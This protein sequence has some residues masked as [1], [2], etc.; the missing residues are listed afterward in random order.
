MDGRDEEI[1]DDDS[2]N[3]KLLAEL[4]EGDIPVGVG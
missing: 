2:E 1:M 3:D 4:N